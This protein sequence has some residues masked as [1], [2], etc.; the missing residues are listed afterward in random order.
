MPPFLS[1]K[2]KESIEGSTSVLENSLSS[3][4]AANL[5]LLVPLGA[6]LQQ[7]WE[8]IRPLQYLSIIALA[9]IVYP[10]NLHLFFFHMVDI[11]SLDVMYGE[12]I[13]EYLFNFRETEPFAP[14]FNEFGVENMTYLLNSSSI[15]FPLVP[16]ILL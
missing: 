5:F 9:Y 12:Q 10:G 16:L 8:V 14:H 13:T 3:L 2:A 6:P 4:V 1:D 11:S 7:L 15:I